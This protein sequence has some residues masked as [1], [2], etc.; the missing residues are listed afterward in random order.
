MTLWAARTAGALHAGHWE[1]WLAFMLKTL[2]SGLLVFGEGAGNASVNRRIFAAMCTVGSL[3][4]LTRF[5][6]MGKEIVVA[7]YFG[8]GDALDAF[9]IALMLPAFA[10]N[11]IAGSLSAALIPTYIHVRETEGLP[12]AQQLVVSVAARTLAFLG[13]AALVLALAV[14]L[15]TPL[16]A[17]GYPPAKRA[18]VQSLVLLLV[19]IVVLSGVTSL[20]S[21]VL[22]AGGRFALASISP[23]ITPL[24]TLAALIL[25]RGGSGIQILALSLS[26]G[27]LLEAAV[28]GVALRRS[29]F[30]LLPRWHPLDSAARAVLR[31]Y[32]PMVAGTFLIGSTA[33]VDQA[34][35]ATLGSGS[36]AALNYGNKL[37]MAGMGIG[38]TAVGS[39]VLPHFSQMVVRQDWN[40]I[41]RTL[42]V[43]LRLLFAITLPLTGL[44]CWFSVPLVR[45]LFQYGAFTAADT[46]LVAGIQVCYALQIPFNIG[47]IL[48]VRLI[49]SLKANAVLM[50]GAAISLPLN[51]ILDLFLMRH[52]GTAGIAL[53]TACV[54]L[55]SFL[56]S[57]VCLHYLLAIRKRR[58]SKRFPAGQGE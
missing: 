13:G 22:N 39:A 19:P 17:S 4:L 51:V 7:K 24:T 28:L 43:Y 14:P 40:A 11:L 25:F 9:Y 20:W 54:Y 52:I 55:G 27:A 57:G 56:F 12:A 31:Q 58:S 16:I 47:G 1:A 38:A 29:G 44:L 2:K 48:L 50:W 8:L 26:A 30:V 49:S 23:L 41:D 5:V 6:A 42:R 33:I 36:V 10:V 35:A 21:A 34:L 3:T 37:V 15:L 53:S 45:M 46:Q 32:V 18:L